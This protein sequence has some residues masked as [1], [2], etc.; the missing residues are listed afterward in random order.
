MPRSV[1]LPHEVHRSLRQHLSLVQ[2]RDGPRDAVDEVHVVLDDHQRMA[3]GQR[4]EQFPGA[5]GLLV[6]HPRHR[7]VEQEQ[8]GFLH[9]EDPDLQPLLLPV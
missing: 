5:D 8:L 3:A 9:Q 2:H 4:L 6:R 1:W 7:F